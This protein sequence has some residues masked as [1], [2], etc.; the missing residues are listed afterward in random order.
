MGILR[1]RYTTNDG[2]HQRLLPFSII[3]GRH[4]IK[5]YRNTLVT[6]AFNIQWRVFSALS[7]GQLYGILKLR[8]DVFVLEQRSIYADADD[9]DQTSWHLCLYDDN[10][11]VGY[12]RL[13]TLQRQNYKIE[14]VVC[15]KTH[16]GRGLGH[17][18]MQASLK[19]ISCLSAGCEV[20]LSAQ[21]QALAF[22]QGYGFVAQN[23]AYDDGGI[24]HMDMSLQL[25]K[26]S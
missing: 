13:R 1:L 24:E 22:Y 15:A 10:K 23:Q 18:L 19:K 17:K 21:T 7:L 11:L 5:Q 3:Y 20:T 2:G 16:R 12:T 8:Q 9:G 26:P 6:S 25:P 14:R 4:A